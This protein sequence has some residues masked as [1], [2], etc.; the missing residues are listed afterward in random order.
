MVCSYCLTEAYRAQRPK[1]WPRVEMEP[2]I[3][4]NLED[5]A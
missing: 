3:I 1:V 4:I 2:A 5:A